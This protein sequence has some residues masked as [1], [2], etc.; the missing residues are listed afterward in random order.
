[1]TDIRYTSEHEWVKLE[2]D[3]IWVGITDYARNALGDLVYVELPSVGRKVAKGDDFAVVESV[4]TAAEVY[5][6][7]AGEVVEVNGTLK[8][9]ADRIKKGLPEGWIAK[10]RISD[11]S[12]LEALMDKEAYD[13]YVAGLG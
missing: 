1:M 4:K 3:I 12:E 7:V 8:D 6:P 13:R 5:S 9:D 10:I 2:G 11:P